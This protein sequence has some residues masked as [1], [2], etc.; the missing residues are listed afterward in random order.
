MANDPVLHAMTQQVSKYRYGPDTMELE[1]R[2]GTLTSDRRFTAGFS[3]E[4]R[5]MMRDLATALQRNVQSDTAHQRWQGGG[6]YTFMNS[7]YDAE[8]IRRRSKQFKDR[9]DHSVVRKRVVNLVNIMTDRPYH[10][11]FA[12]QDE[13]PVPYHR[14]SVHYE[15]LSKEPPDFVQ[16]G[17]RIE[18][19]ETI[20]MIGDPTL[21]VVFQ[22][23]LTQLSRRE[24]NKRNCAGSPCSW[25]SEIELKTKLQPLANKIQER[26]QDEWV[27][28][29]FL[30]R[31][32]LMLGSHYT[33]PQKKTNH[34][35][36]P[37]TFQLV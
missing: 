37:P 17:R 26:S 32:G 30:V 1:I 21:N 22:Y 6:D 25:H 28:K 3:H 27:A 29:L 24:N 2:V 5:H 19:T 10:L 11:R 8:G 36:K 12:L 31:A 13:E 34:L 7:F 15:K 35:L 9:T 23:D 18:F 4:H 16:I 20:G 33:D 14:G